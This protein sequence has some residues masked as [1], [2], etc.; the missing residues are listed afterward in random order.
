MPDKRRHLGSRGEDLAVEV[1]LTRGWRLLDRN[2]R[3]RLGEIDLVAAD[4]SVIV[5]IEVKTRHSTAFGTPAEA[6]GSIKQRRLLL[7]A[8]Q[9]LQSRGL[10]ESPSRFDV[11]AIRFEA[12][13]PIVDWIEDAF[14][15]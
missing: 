12:G 13:E 4:G 11:V 14:G 6:V 8:Q 5:F 7:L 3:C 1:L 9:Y 10:V 2:Y 15:A